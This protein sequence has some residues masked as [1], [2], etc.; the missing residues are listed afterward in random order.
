M[1]FLSP[2]VGSTVTLTNPRGWVSLNFTSFATQPGYDILF[3]F[4]GPSTRSPLIGIYSGSQLLREIMH[5]RGG[6]LPRVPT[7]CVISVHCR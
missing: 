5:F 1:W 6:T 7:P 3:I 2:R 4:E